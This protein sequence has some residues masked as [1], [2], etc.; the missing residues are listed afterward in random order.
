MIFFLKFIYIFVD[1]V[2]VVCDEQIKRSMW[3]RQKAMWINIWICVIKNREG[4]I[5]YHMF[6]VLDDLIKICIVPLF[7]FYKSIQIT[8]VDW[9]IY[10]VI[11]KMLVD[12]CTVTQRMTSKIINRMSKLLVNTSRSL[13]IKTI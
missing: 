8:F 10:P 13:P 9:W 12:K 3:K 4:N 6:A 2:V 1:F 11:E 5:N 7:Q